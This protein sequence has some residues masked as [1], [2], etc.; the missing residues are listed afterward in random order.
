MD[1][2]N[3]DVFTEQGAAT[4]DMTAG[5]V[6]DTNSRLLGRSGEAIDAVSACAPVEITDAHSLLQLCEADCPMIW[7]RLPRSTRPK[8]WGSAE[9]PV[10]Q[11]ECNLHGHPLAVLLWKGTC[12]N[13][14][15]DEDWEQSIWM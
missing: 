1:G 5:K 4:S 9:G 14:L 11:L 15:L 6:L 13:I 10:V 2:L 3:Y 8:S 7:V 12:E